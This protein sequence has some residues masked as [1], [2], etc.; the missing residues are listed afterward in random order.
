MACLNYESSC[1]FKD[2]LQ[3][4]KLPHNGCIGMASPQYVSSYEFQDLA[5]MMLS[6]SWCIGMASPKYESSY[7]HGD[8]LYMTILLPTLTNS[9]YQEL[10]RG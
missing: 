8:L 3:L 2:S 5:L 1:A 7:D 4:K 6:N 9:T 10:F